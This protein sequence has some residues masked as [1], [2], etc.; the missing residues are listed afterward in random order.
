MRVI[1]GWRPENGP[2]RFSVWPLFIGAGLSG[3]LVWGFWRAEFGLMSL[4]I[5]LLCLIGLLFLLVQVVA[6][7]VVA[8]IGGRWRRAVSDLSGIAA[9]CV[10]LCATFRPAG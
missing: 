1:G 9:G 10:I 7:V 6:S 8:L 2:A 5:V 4:A 3:L